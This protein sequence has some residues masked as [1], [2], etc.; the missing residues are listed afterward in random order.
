MALKKIFHKKVKLIFAISTLSFSVLSIAD[1]NISIN[2]KISTS[3]LQEHNI[4]KMDGRSI[5][6]Q[7]C[8]SCHRY[9]LKKYDF[10][11]EKHLLKAPPM[12][13]ISRRIKK[14]IKVDDEDIHRFVVISFIKEYIKHPSF[15]YYMCDDTAVARFDVMPPITNLSEKEYQ[16][17]SEWIY[18]HY[19]I[20][21]YDQK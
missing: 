11:K 7:K 13:E 8:A 16:T 1:N 4:S 12:N 14:T 21:E 10:G 5:F 9:R 18:D 17:I 3:T 15:S 19:S 20:K 6:N 2:D